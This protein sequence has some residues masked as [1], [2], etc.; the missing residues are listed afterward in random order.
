MSTGRPGHDPELV[1]R[2][3][4]LLPTLVDDLK[5]LVAIP[6]VA[7]DG[8]PAEPLFEAHDFVVELLRDAGVESIEQ[9]RIEGKTAPVVI[10]RIPAPDGAPTV[11]LYTHYDV[12]PAGDLELGTP[13]RSRQPRSTVRCTV[14]AQPIPRPTSSAS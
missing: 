11:L 4:A 5:R 2:V 1:D 9:L 7:T 10:G 6:S 8:F 14:A 3:E 12:V 13:R